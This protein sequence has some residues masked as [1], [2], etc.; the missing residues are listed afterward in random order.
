MSYLEQQTS[1]I[2]QAQVV[3]ALL[4][5]KNL[6]LHENV[7]KEFKET[8]K[9]NLSENGGLLYW[10]NEEENK[11]VRDW[12]KETGNIVYHVIKNNMEFGLCYSLLYVSPHADEWQ[13]D[14]E[15]LKEGYPLVYVKNAT[16]N[17]CSEYG[18]IGIKS[19]IGGLVRVA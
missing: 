7:I 1:E 17:T 3:E 13:Y 6:K 16:D 11:M 12:E 14:N 15:D 8:G 10:L 2:A 4:R 9:I 19:S 5:M 18:S